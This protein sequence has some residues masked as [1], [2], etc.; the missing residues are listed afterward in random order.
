MTRTRPK[1]RRAV[2][3]TFLG[4]A[5]GSL[6]AI[7]AAEAGAGDANCPAT[8][9]IVANDLYSS[10]QDN[11]AMDPGFERTPSSQLP[12]SIAWQNA[13]SPAWKITTDSTLTT[14]HNGLRSAVRD[15]T[16]TASAG[17]LL[18]R[19]SGEARPGEQFEVNGWVNTTGVNATSTG[20]V[21]IAWYDLHGGQ[22]SITT[23]KIA[24]TGGTWT[25]VGEL[26]TAPAGT[27]SA[28]AG[29]TVTDQSTGIWHADDLVARQRTELPGFG[30]TDKTAATGVTQSVDPTK[31]QKR[32]TGNCAGTPTTTRAIGNVNADGTVG[33][34]AAPSG[35]VLRGSLATLVPI[36]QDFTDRLQV[37]MALPVG[38]WRIT[39]TMNY[40]APNLDHVVTIYERV[41]CKAN[42]SVG[43]TSGYSRHE[44]NLGPDMTAAGTLTMN[45]VTTIGAAGGNVGIY[46]SAPN[47]TQGAAFV[48]YKDARI[49]ATPEVSTSVV[50]LTTS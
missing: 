43:D 32:V 50:S 35:G 15:G 26:A 20:G 11:Q 8:P 12:N 9:C 37:K 29:F 30:L 28:R 18:N 22:I 40:A 6:L 13:G 14:A 36:F 44:E 33:C 47:G 49:I 2:S 10:D 3:L 7:P 17:T 42:S 38:T 21:I 16:G 23:H 31:I 24:P 4:V 19:Y 39:A 41:E 34:V 1:T 25:F 45:L 5:V 46:C 48:T 27:V